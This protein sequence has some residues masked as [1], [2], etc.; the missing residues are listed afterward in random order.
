MSGVFHIGHLQAG[1]PIGRAVLVVAGGDTGPLRVTATAPGYAFERV[2]SAAP[3]TTPVRKALSARGVSVFVLELEGPLPASTI[4]LSAERA[5]IAI[6]KRVVRPIPA[7]L[8]DEGISFLLASCLY[9]NPTFLATLASALERAIGPVGERG[10]WS[11]ADPRFALLLGDNVYLDV[12]P[13][14]V[15]GN[16]AEHTAARYAKA[17]VETD[18]SARALSALP[19][20]SLVDD[21][22]LYDGYPELEPHVMRTWLP[23][24]RASFVDAAHDALR[25]FQTSKNPRGAGHS[26]RF[27]VGPLSFF[28]LDTRISRTRIRVGEPRLTSEADLAAMEEWARTLTAPGMLV[29]SQPLLSPKGS[30][31]EPSYSAFKADY[32]RI[33]S[34]LRDAPFDIAVLAGDLHTSRVL[35]LDIGGR[36]VTEVVS[37]P[38][39]RVP[40]F[41]KN[42]LHRVF[43]GAEDQEPEVID[44]P[45]TVDVPPD[46]V[47]IGCAEYVMGTAAPNTFALLNAR[48]V[49]NDI[50]VEVEFVDH[51][52]D[53]LAHSEP[54][55]GGRGPRV[56]LGLPCS[57]RF[58]LGRRTIASAKT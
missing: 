31:I 18:D 40:S 43:G 14:R 38:M 35:E 30:V 25:L 54:D 22:E 53:R 15:E 46:D 19:A 45:M 47:D 57:A 1:A 36:L 11:I 21:H 27:E 52:A 6:A 51:A 3:A 32:A 28:C 7:E 41:V 58:R 33:L 17:F 48:A 2:V 56:A 26:F 8:G 50:V 55:R 24:V 9:P 34:A 10:D 5:G 29:V 16:G 44:I 20:L 42:L 49:G 12:H 39:V 37:S 4:T 23:H 13:D